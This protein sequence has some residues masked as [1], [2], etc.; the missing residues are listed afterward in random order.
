MA[1]KVIGDPVTHEVTTREKVASKTESDPKTSSRTKGDDSGPNYLRRSTGSCHDICKYGKPH[2]FPEK[3][4][5]PIRRKSLTRSE[6]DQSLATVLARS[7]SRTKKPN[8]ADRHGSSASVQSCLSVKSLGSNASVSIDYAASATTEESASAET[9]EVMDPETLHRE[10]ASLNV[11]ESSNEEVS[12]HISCTATESAVQKLTDGETLL[13]RDGRPDGASKAANLEVPEAVQSSSI[14]RKL[15]LRRGLSRANGTKP[16][17]PVKFKR[18]NMRT[19]PALSSSQGF[20]SGRKTSIDQSRMV[21][22][23]PQ[24]TLAFQAATLSSKAKKTTSKDGTETALIPGTSPSSPKASVTQITGADSR[25]KSNQ[26]PEG[27]RNGIPTRTR[28]WDKNAGITPGEEVCNS[29]SVVLVATD[30]KYSSSTSSHEA[31]VLNES[32]YSDSEN[33]YSSMDSDLKEERGSRPRNRVELSSK[34]EASA[35]VKLR[36]RRGKV[37]EP[38]SENSS[39]RRLRFSRGR[40]LDDGR[41]PICD[42]GRKNFRKRAADHGVSTKPG[43]EKVVLRHQDVQG[44]KDVQVLL[45]NVIE[46]TASKLVK[47]RKSKVKALVGAFETVIYLQEGKHAVDRPSAIIS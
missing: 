19:V 27:P 13:D 32:G 34:E 16:S 9:S 25:K 1:K 39:Q 31:G 21:S 10:S 7:G 41:G 47:T 28:N 42:L 29:F 23:V 37:V 8:E 46:E 15:N 38:Q 30:S 22:L 5:R 17:A 33:E 3:P 2:K 18:G 14:Q 6:G 26:T 35:A 20:K 12:S 36:F 43:A 45:N 11:L 4:W 24:K 40:V 44:K